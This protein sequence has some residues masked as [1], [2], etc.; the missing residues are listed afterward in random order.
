MCYTA[1]GSY[2][3]EQTSRSSSCLWGAGRNTDECFAKFAILGSVGGFARPVL[4]P[5]SGVA[6]TEFA[7]LLT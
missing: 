6:F 1:L 7:G 5:V 3:A 2:D 4:S